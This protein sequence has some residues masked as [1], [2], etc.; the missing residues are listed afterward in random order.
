MANTTEYYAS[1]ANLTSIL[2]KINT[3]LS[4]RY[5]KS[6][7][8]AA[9]ASAIAGVTSFEYEIVQSLPQ[10]GEKGIIYLVANS[11]AG[12]N[13][14]DEYIWIEVSNV[15]SFEKLG[16]RDLDTSDFLIGT[17][18]KVDTSTL[19]KTADLTGNGFTI[20]LSSATKASLALAD[21]AVQD[22]DL[23][24]F[25]VGTDV[26]VDGTT[27]TK[28]P[29]QSGNGFTLSSHSA[30][31]V[32]GGTGID[33]AQD[34]SDYEVGLDT[35]TQ[36]SLALADTALQSADIADFMTNDDVAGTTDEIVATK[37]SSGNG[38]TLS[39]ASAVTS[40]LGKADT[41]VQKADVSGTT[42]EVVVTPAVSGNG[43]TISLASAISSGAAAGA[44]ALQPGDVEPLS[45][46]DVND[47]LALITDDP[48][49]NGN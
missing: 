45:S 13:I 35:A 12:Q 26:K 10:E 20:D 30:T 7:A 18:V 37:A 36:A 8:D 41:A 49:S 23:T 21:S 44:T 33:V 48:V 43:V 3:K 31:T 22:S 47:L 14:Y 5:T 46:S 42:D 40:S 9:I 29:D 28:T 17:D 2:T 32:S 25:L 24:D 34:G 16:W 1:K 27:I 11:G 39:L 6:E 38:V 4:N 15:G 19:S